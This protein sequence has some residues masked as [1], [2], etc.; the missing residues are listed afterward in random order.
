MPIPI[1]TITQQRALFGCLSGNTPPLRPA[2]VLRDLS[3]LLLFFFDDIDSWPFS[4][5]TRSVAFDAL[6]FFFIFLL[7]GRL[8]HSKSHTFLLQVLY[9]SLSLSTRTSNLVK[10]NF[11]SNPPSGTALYNDSC[12]W[13]HRF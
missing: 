12:L 9:P 3:S 11:F 2:E 5:G 6:A 4:P 10:P 7:E 8:F 13:A 1:L